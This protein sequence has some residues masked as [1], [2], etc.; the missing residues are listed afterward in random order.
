MPAQADALKD[1]SSMPPVSVTM[2]A[3]YAAA[4]LPPLLPLGVS[5]GAS[6]HAAAAGGSP[7]AARTATIRFPVTGRKTPSF[8]YTPTPRGESQAGAYAQANVASGDRPG[9]LAHRYVGAT[10]GWTERRFRALGARIARP[11]A[12]PAVNLSARP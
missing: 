9:L 4:A 10:G 11:S 6:P 2:H 12:L 7:P 3:L 5:L 1:R 8:H